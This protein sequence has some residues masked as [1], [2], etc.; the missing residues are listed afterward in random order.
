MS[1]KTQQT[2]PNILVDHE[3]EQYI[4]ARNLYS[5]LNLDEEFTPWCKLILKHFLDKSRYKKLRIG[6]GRAHKK[7]D[8]LIA[9]DGLDL[10][11]ELAMLLLR[12]KVRRVQRKLLA[13]Q[14]RLIENSD[15]RIVLSMYNYG[16]WNDS[17]IIN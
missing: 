9:V 16:P 1:S 17:G 14:N 2:Q 13:A 4:S 10:F 6:T 11:M 3:G 8:Y 12:K 7:T 5:S 15:P